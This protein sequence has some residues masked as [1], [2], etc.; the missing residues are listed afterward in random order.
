MA[1]LKLS[2]SLDNSS[3]KPNCTV[4]S[5]RVL[6]QFSISLFPGTCGVCT[7]KP[8]CNLQPIKVSQVL[9]EFSDD[10]E[11]SSVELVSV[12]S[13][14]SHSSSDVVSETSNSKRSSFKGSSRKSSVRVWRRFRNVKKLRKDSNLS[15]ISCENSGGGSGDGGTGSI[16]NK[17]VLINS[18]LD[19]E[20]AED[21]DL[22][23]LESELSLERCNAI[24]KQLENS[25]DDKAFRFFEWMKENGRLRNNLDAYNLIFR[26]LGRKGDWYRAEKMIEEIIMESGCEL[27]CQIFN[28]IIYACHKGGLTDLGT[29]WFHMMLENG[30]RPNVATFGMLMSLYQKHWKVEEAEFTFSRMRDLSIVCHSAYS[31]M[32][33]I[34]TRMR[35]YDKAEEVIGFLR[36]DEVILNLENW[37]VVLNAYSQQGKLGEA[38]KELVSMGR[39]GFAPNIIAYNTLIT[40]YGKLSNMAAAQRLCNELEKVGLQPDATTCRSMIEGWGRVN[41]YKEAKWYYEKLKSLGVMPNSANL[42]TMINLQAKNE[43]EEGILSTIDDMMKIGCQKSSVLGIVLQA[44]EKAERFEK[45]SS[46]LKGSLY[47]HALKNQTSCSI[48]VLAYVKNGLINDALEVL[49]EKQWKDSV[50]EDNLYHLAI[51]TCK[52]LGHLENACRIFTFMP[53]AKG[54]PNLH[55]CCTMID[56]FSTMC[57]FN[58]AENIYLK[59]KQSGISLDM[60]AFSVVIR[61]YAKSGALEK[62]CLVIEAMEEQKNLVP[63]VYLLR[64]MFRIYQRC[65]MLDK[66]K[67][68]YYRALKTGVVWDQE[69]YNCV[70]N[71]CARAL[72]VDELSKLFD[73]MLQHGYAPNII[74]INVMLDVYGKSG[75]F[76]RARKLFWM[77]KKRGLI[78]DVSYNTMIAAYGQIKDF[79][80]MSAT[81]RTMEFNGLS[82]S[83]EAYNCMLD[84]YGKKGEMEKF[85]DILRRMKDSRCVWD[86]YTYNI[87]INIYGE[88]KWVDELSGVLLELRELQLGL[89]LC[90]YNTLIKAYGIAGMVEDAVELVKEMR[91]KGIEPDRVT[92]TNLINALRKNDMFLEAV[93]W[94][95]WM[96]QMGL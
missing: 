11:L 21:F 74:A 96:K 39:A 72:P 88:Q 20:I 36:K 61:M 13:V 70:I 7:V 22:S 76:K 57:L 17:Y 49:A 32:I 9:T 23:T 35:F 2:V 15:S 67:D 73:E 81:V 75:L 63:D 60:I 71:C 1:S 77:A 94:S 44:Y 69:M 55:I 92:Y 82:V 19:N 42:F 5:F 40:G 29:K 66:L 56:I 58:E 10:S 16:A 6:G 3:T 53:K 33:T 8:F 87:M 91:E 78:D 37:L 24:L 90:G 64:D 62:A 18:L 30:V 25:D 34:Y 27:N 51:C 54:K 86:S 85:R 95:L 68:L 50:F 43:D 38:E 12:D 48:L 79:K 46:I 65:A 26:V 59:L 31:A 45:V 52:E 4:N 14:I 41:N 84:A 28:T 83:L 89:D 93:K 47:D 80:N